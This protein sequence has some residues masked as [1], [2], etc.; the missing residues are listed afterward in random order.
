MDEKKYLTLEGLQKYHN[1]LIEYIE[2]R[3]GDLTELAAEATVDLETGKITY[4]RPQQ[5]NQE[6]KYYYP[7][8]FSLFEEEEEEE[9]QND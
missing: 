6:D 2:A 5:E 3:F 1:K 9:K 7:I 4:I 8:P